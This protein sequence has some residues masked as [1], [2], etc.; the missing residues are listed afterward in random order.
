MAVEE[1]LEGHG[2]WRCFW[3]S[4]EVDT[5]MFA[6]RSCC[7]RDILDVRLFLEHTE[8]ARTGHASPWTATHSVLRPSELG[9]ECVHR[10]GL[11]EQFWAAVQAL[12]SEPGGSTT[13]FQQNTTNTQNLAIKLPTL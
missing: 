10:Q 2:G 11:E 8:R 9:L 1:A 13:N 7:R 3:A 4:I 12:K 6:V 5:E